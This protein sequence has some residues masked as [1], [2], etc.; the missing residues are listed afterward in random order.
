MKMPPFFRRKVMDRKDEFDD[1]SIKQKVI[2]YFIAKLNKKFVDEIICYSSFEQDDKAFCKGDY[3]VFDGYVV[4]VPEGADF[5]YRFAFMEFKERFEEYD[6]PLIEY[7]KIYKWLEHYDNWKRF[8]YLNL[9][10]SGLWCLP[11]HNLKLWQWKDDL[12]AVEIDGI[13]PFSFDR[14]KP[15]LGG[16]SLGSDIN[17]KA[18]IVDKKHWILMEDFR[19]NGDE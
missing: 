10:P 19:R 4:E 6:S 16:K 8:Y 11:V 5:C 13:K 7:K 18:L 9:L 17:K 3:S 2:D 14:N 15:R 12:D 1:A